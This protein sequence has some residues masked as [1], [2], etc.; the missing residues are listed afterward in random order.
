MPWPRAGPAIARPN[1]RRAV[2]RPVANTAWLRWVS[3][4]GRFRSSHGPLRPTVF[5]PMH[6]GSLSPSSPAMPAGRRRKRRASPASDDDSRS[7]MRRQQPRGRVRSVPG[8]DTARYRR[9]RHHAG[10]GAPRPS[11]LRGFLL[12]WPA[13][14]ASPRRCR[15]RRR[16]ET[17]AAKPIHADTSCARGDHRAGVPGTP[18]WPCRGRAAAR[19]A[20]PAGGCPVRCASRSRPRCAARCGSWCWSAPHLRH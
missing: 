9:P 8:T 1:G 13:A 18:R 11:L 15:R 10:S 19:P 6:A 16:P 5:P 3:S 14:S 7:A 12:R 17:S 4:V 20:G 2:H